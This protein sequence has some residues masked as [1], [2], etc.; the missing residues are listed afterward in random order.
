MQCAMC[1]V[2]IDH[3]HYLHVKSPALQ[4]RQSLGLHAL[5]QHE[6]APAGATEQH[7]AYVRHRLGFNVNS[8]LVAAGCSYTCMLLLSTVT[9]IA[10]GLHEELQCTVMSAGAP[11]E[12]AA[13]PPLSGP[14]PLPTPAPAAGEQTRHICAHL[15]A[16]CLTPL[17]KQP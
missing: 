17:S 7:L 11:P 1:S 3:S 16:P 10:G 15:Q 9:T 8:C 13:E 5:Q 4:P 2:L 12:F 6:P 14:A